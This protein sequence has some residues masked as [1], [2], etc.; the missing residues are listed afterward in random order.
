LLLGCFFGFFLF[1]PFLNRL[2]MR[3]FRTI[4]GKEEFAE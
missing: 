4:S 2:K 3:N 1:H